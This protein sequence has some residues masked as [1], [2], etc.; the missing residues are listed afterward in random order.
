MTIDRRRFLQVT[1]I[2]IASTVGSAACAPDAGRDPTALARPALLVAMD[3]AVVREIGARYR[4]TVPAE[5]DAKAI[6]SAI[7]RDAR[8]GLWLPW[9]QSPSLEQQISDDFTAGRTVV[10][11]GWVLSET[12]ARQCALFSLG[13]V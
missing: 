12:E 3:E 4:E 6:R 10:V 9:K 7:A 11:N 8:R 2:G 13:V 1:A 5:R